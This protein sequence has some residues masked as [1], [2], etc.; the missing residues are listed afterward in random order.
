MLV[1]EQSDSIAYDEQP[2]AC[3][4]GVGGMPVVSTSL[5]DSRQSKSANIAYAEQTVVRCPGMAGMP[6]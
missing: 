1:S 2:S 4:P 6:V 3:C 5:A